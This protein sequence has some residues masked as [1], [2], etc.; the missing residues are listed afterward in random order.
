MFGFATFGPRLEKLIFAASIIVLVI[1]SYFFY[2]KND[3]LSKANVEVQH[4]HDVQLNLERTVTAVEAMENTERGYLIT[5]DPSFVTTYP[6]YPKRIDRYYSTLDSLI[7]DPNEQTALQGLKKLLDRKRQRTESIFS[8]YHFTPT[9]SVVHQTYLEDSERLLDSI[10]KQSDRINQYTSAQLVRRQ[11]AKAWYSFVTPLTAVFLLLVSLLLI[12]WYYIRLQRELAISQNYLDRLRTNATQQNE[13]N[14]TFAHAEEMAQIGNFKWD[15]SSHKMICSQNLM[16]LLGATTSDEV[17]SFES[18]M[19]YVHPD[20]KTIVEEMSNAT[21]SHGER[22]TNDFRIVRRDGSVMYV[23]CSMRATF[24]NNADVRLLGIIQDITTPL[25]AQRK[26]ERRK[27]MLKKAQQI[28]HMGSWEWDFVNGKLEW[29]DEM[30]RL[31]GLEPGTDLNVISTQENIHDEDK[32]AVFAAI[33]QTRLNGVPMDIKYRRF[34]GQKIVYLHS[35]GTPMIDQ[36]GKVIGLFGITIDTTEQLTKEEQLRETQ[37]FNAR[38]SELAPNLIYVFD[39]EQN[40]LLYINK[41]TED[42]TGSTVEQLYSPGA[43]RQ[44]IHPDDLVSFISHYDQFR[45]AESD[46]VIESEYRI[47]LKSGEWS[48]QFTRECVFKRNEQGKVVQV[49]G[50]ATDIT[51]IRSATA[52]LT[53]LN[54]MLQ[55]KNEALQSSNDE[56]DSFSYVAGHDLLEPLRKIQTFTTLITEADGEKLSETSQKYFTRMH[57]AAGRMQNLINDLLSYS[58]I[59]STEKRFIPVDLNETLA[60]VKLALHDSIDEHSAI[61][62][63]SNLPTVDGIPFQLQQL[64]ENLLA[65]S[66]KY[67]KQDVPPEIWIDASIVDLKNGDHGFDGASG[68]YYCILFKDNGIGFEPQYEKKIFEI[69]QR[70]HGKH[71]Y[72][73]T[74]IGLTICKRIL[75]HHDGFISAEGRPDEGA[76]FK[77]LLPVQHQKFTAAPVPLQ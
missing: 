25:L 40:K 34:V 2:A 6:T 30:Y 14:Q 67:R 60:Q 28:A 44:L 36:Q 33:D 58:R 23:K 65:N 31:L 61:I 50:I 15:L 75:H 8:K 73:G 35:K 5:G 53:E 55:Q 16:R 27:E 66:I 32:A 52:R 77:V 57:A 1:I 59:N 12:I 39:I 3:D 13:V 70:L 4:S 10:R 42:V 19:N 29:S 49:L 18:F 11:A 26:F 17:I 45:L 51:E 64:F 74:G 63:A 20:D 47:R 43:L 62:H 9:L 46:R 56:L 7:Y 48:T 24:R 41:K 68:N 22:V 54:D 37:R 38:I 69:F 71:E 72:P 76:L 21:I